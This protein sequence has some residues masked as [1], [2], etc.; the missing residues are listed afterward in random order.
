MINKKLV[1]T[2]ATLALALAITIPAVTPTLAASQKT[3][4]L[5]LLNLMECKHLLLLMKW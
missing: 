4:K 5:N 1:K 2:G 3:I